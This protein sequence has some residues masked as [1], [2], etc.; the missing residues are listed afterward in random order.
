MAKDVAYS[1]VPP[2][3][4]R[5]RLD[6]A[7]LPFET[8]D[9]LDPLK[10]IIGQ[11]RALE[12]FRFGLGVHRKGYHVFVTGPEGTGRM[13]TIL[14]ILEE[15]AAK[16]RA[17]DD[18]CYVYNF[19]D[20]DSPPLVRLKAGMGRRFK[21]DIHNLVEALKKDVPTLFE[22]EDYLNMK[23]EIIEKYDAKG[24][25]FIKEL[26]SRVK[27]EGFAIVQVEMGPVTRPVVM[28]I[29]NEKPTPLERVEQ[30]VEQGEYPREKFETIKTKHRQLTEQVDRIFLE[31]HDMQREVQK[32]LEE[33]DRYIF[34]K[35]LEEPLSALKTK[36]DPPKVH[37][38]LDDMAQDMADNLAVFR[39]GGQ[40]QAGPMGMPV[41][42][43]QGNPFQPYQ[44]NLLVDNSKTEGQPI[45]VEN[46]P[47]YRNLFGTMER[48]VDRSGLWTT[49]FSRIHVGSL[50]KANGG[51]LV[52]NLLDAI[53]EP[54]VWAGLKRALLTHQMEL[55]TFDPF[56]LFTTTGLKPEPIDLDLKVVVLAEPWVYYRL[57]S[58]D[59][60]TKRIFRV[61]AD[62]A[63]SMD[64]NDAVVLQVARYIRLRC[65]EEKILPLDRQ[66]VAAVIEEGVRMVGR[67]EKIT[68][69]LFRMNEILLEADFWAREAKQTVVGA[70]HVRKALDSRIYRSN[71]AEEQVQEMIDRGTVL[72][73]TQ[74][75]V[76]GQINGL[77]VYMLGDYAFGKPT[78]ITATTSMGRAGVINIEREA[79]LS[80]STHN[81]GV[82]IL[83]GYLR[84]RY[85]QDRPLSVTASLAFE[86]SYGGVDGDS[87]SSTEVYAILSSLSQIPL[88]QDIAVTGSINQKGEIQA[89][90]GVNYKIEGFFDCCKHKGLTGSE[91]VLIPRSNVQDLMLREEVVQAV[92]DGR[93]HIHAVDT[94][95]QGMEILTGLPMGEPDDEGNYPEG[96]VNHAVFRRLSEFAAGLKKFGEEEKDEKEKT[97]GTGGCNKC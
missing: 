69:N 3:E 53:V 51:F 5:W 84:R 34:L 10:E 85:A 36:Y 13:Q 77:S 29:V 6:P 58:V 40:P 75:A 68:A 60:D 11:D 56:Y 43:A 54:G 48:A 88:R 25:Q 15:M 64:R 62:F 14:K 87:A 21:E 47:N 18:L 28:P 94:V 4:L 76:V 95:D 50:V 46:Y 39:T 41:P 81:K 8:T 70:E 7:T 42:F 71:L 20:P 31:M 16:D 23:K 59:T 17:P 73:D 38:Y 57:N 32:Q 92:A 52:V 55:H 22:S 2:K 35:S 30:L 19:K 90:G 82:L 89:I 91:G 86:Q 83:S 49:D 33:M 96:T 74:G 12:A 78:R 79:D 72:I 9:G 80:G 26:D 65:D 44:V 97:K 37:T 93:F 61:R 24:K 67:K 27:K 63:G 45:V 66:A 1:E